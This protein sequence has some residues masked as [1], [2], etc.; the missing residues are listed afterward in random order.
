VKD[1]IVVVNNKNSE[2]NPTGK[3]ALIQIDIIK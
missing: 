3:E 1:A 2:T